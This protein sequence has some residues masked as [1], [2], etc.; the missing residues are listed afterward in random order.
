MTKNVGPIDR[1]FRIILGGALLYLALFA[2]PNGFNWIGWLGIIPL[3][4]A[5]IGN[6]PLYSMLGLNTCPVKR[7]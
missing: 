6:C 1:I 2:P 3:L 7:A 4:T 5:A